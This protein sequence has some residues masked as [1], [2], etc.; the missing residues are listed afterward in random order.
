MA[1][2]R[3]A[4]P[5]GWW[6]GMPETRPPMPCR[7]ARWEPRHDE[8][9]VRWLNDP[10]IRESFGITTQVTLEGHR[11]W[12]E[13]KT[14]VVGWA[15]ESA[16]GRHCGNLLLDVNGRHRSAY[17]QIYIGE[18]GEQ[19]RGL[20]T[21]AMALALD[22]AFGPLA[23]HRVWLHTRSGNPRAMHVYRKLG[24]REEG[25]ERESIL[26]PDGAWADQTRWALLAP[27]W[28]GA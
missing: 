6:P 1:A 17:L 28:R 27:E 22:Q 21:A 12:R 7:L 8:A 3:S 16:Q 5:T 11:A 4:S 10:A 19:G 25:I 15:I 14:S 18:A 9:T 26:L 24:F 23:L 20:G 13:Q 2:A